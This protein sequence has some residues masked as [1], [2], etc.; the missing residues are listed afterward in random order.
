MALYN[1]LISQDF[2]LPSF[3]SPAI[4]L[5]SLVRVNDFANFICPSIGKL[6]SKVAGLGELNA[7]TEHAYKII[8]AHVFI[9]TGKVFPFEESPGREYVRDL[10]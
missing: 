2:Y 10:V 8:N 5:Q 4:T 9:E 7:P 6:N 3:T 1:D